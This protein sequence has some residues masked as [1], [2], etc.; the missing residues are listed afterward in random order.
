M[1]Q[2]NGSAAAAVTLSSTAPLQQQQPQQ[3]QTASPPLLPSVLIKHGTPRAERSRP[4]FDSKDGTPKKCKQC[5]CKNSR[6]LK[7]YC[8]CFASGTYCEGCNCVNCC[9][10]VENES[11]RQEAVEATLERNPNAFRP[12]IF[13]SPSL[14]DLRE[15]VGEQPLIGKHNKGC[16]CKKSGC[17]KKYCEC[18]QANILCSDNCKCVDCKNFEGSE[19]RRA[20]FH[21]DHNMGL[22][23]MVQMAANGS[24]QTIPGYLSPS[25]PMK[26]RRTH[27]LVFAGPGLKEQGP[28]GRTPSLPVQGHLAATVS[29]A[30]NTPI[31]SMSTIA[32]GSASAAPVKVVH[33]S[34]LAGV[35][36]LE[37]I[38]ELCKLL[39][40]V[41]AEA[42]KDFLA[43]QATETGGSK[44]SKEPSP[45]IGREEEVPKQKSDERSDPLESEKASPARMVSA[46][47][48]DV[49]VDTATQQRAMSPGTLAL[50]CDEKD[51]LFTAPPS[52]SGGLCSTEFSNTTPSHPG[53]LYA[54]QER[55]ILLE[56]REC[57]RRII[58]VGKRRADQGSTLALKEK[59]NNGDNKNSTDN[60]LDPSCNGVDSTQEAKAPLWPLRH[61][62]SEDGKAMVASFAVSMLFSGIGAEP[63]SILSLSMYPTFQVGDRIIAEKVSYV[64]RKP[65]VNEI[66]IFKAP[67][68]LQKVGYNPEE[69][70]IKRIVAK[71]GDLV[72]VQNG[73]LVVNGRARSE[74]F[75]VEP[76]AYDM[77]LTKVPQGHV[78]VMGDNRNNSFDSHVWGPLPTKNIFGRSI[79]RYWPPARLGTTVFGAEQL[80]ETALPQLGMMTHKN[81]Q[82]IHAM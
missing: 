45:G 6:C 1:Q 67:Q 39:V 52:P 54:E 3:Q 48:D 34:L 72:Q 61:L 74:D 47:G 60:R 13:S 10:N 21:G 64:F 44:S 29:T 79:V 35:V 14:R 19:E 27:E 81:H 82:V 24:S 33:R 65:S 25:P 11:V 36:Q 42:Q 55:A 16:H 69:V 40:I 71:A 49:E 46:V 62:T 78:F 57:L 66:V 4:A 75:V 12:K 77:K 31:T 53:Q 30:V 70:F 17:L 20:L 80:L 76:A 38:Q 18:F 2:S 73:K 15:D 8:E 41:S 7:L 32:G 56:Y 22:N 58:A 68:I 26:K 50:M 37:A 5:N 9:N 63:R 43:Q 51:P 23:F 28:P 59:S